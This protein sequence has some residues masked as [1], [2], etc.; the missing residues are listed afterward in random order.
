MEYYKNIL[1]I[2][3]AE[4]TSGDPDA[5][6][7]KDRPVLTEASFKYYRSKKSIQVVRRACYGQTVLVSYHSLPDRVKERVIRKYG[8]PEQ[9]TGQYVLR[10]MVTRD[11]NAEQFY[12]DYTLDDKGFEHLDPVYVELYTANASVLNAVILR[13][14]FLPGL[15]GDQRRAERHPGGIRLPPAQK[16]PVAETAGR[17]LPVGELHSPRIRQV[18]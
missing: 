15:A 11:T 2:S 6:E 13:T 5:V 1:C 14:S 7:E 17:P 8:D 9:R 18:W 3:Y 12:K 16:S 10:N 4:L